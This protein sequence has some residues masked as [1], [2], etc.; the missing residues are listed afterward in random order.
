MMSIYELN[1]NNLRILKTRKV[2]LSCY[3]CGKPLQIKDKVLSA[4]T[5][6]GTKLR[7]ESCAKRIKMV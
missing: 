7:H 1:L 6:C 3:T 4:R 2:T 5:R